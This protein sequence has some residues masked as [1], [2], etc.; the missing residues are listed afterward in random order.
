MSCTSSNNCAEYITMP[1]INSRLCAALISP[2]A[3]FTWCTA[4]MSLDLDCQF[5]TLCTSSNHCAEYI[6][7]PCIDESL[8]AA[9]ISPQATFTW[10]TAHMSQDLD[11][12]FITLCTFSN[13]CAEYI[14]MLPDTGRIVGT[15]C[16]R[17]IHKSRAKPVVKMR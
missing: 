3:T 13:H 10:R 1:R 14:T 6:T 11:L 17:R 9:L 12:Q 4:H 2:Q 7:M 15:P 5:S 16:G 8:Y